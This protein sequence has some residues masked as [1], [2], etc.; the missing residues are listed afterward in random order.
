MSEQAYP[1]ALTTVQRVKDL[2]GITVSNADPVLLRLVNSATDFIQN[3]CNEFFAQKTYSNELYSIW[4]ERQEYLMLNHGNVTALTSF[5][6]RAGTP[7]TPNWTNFVQDQYELVEPDGSG[8]ARSGMVRIYAGFAPL[9]YT[10]TNAIRATYTAGFLISWPD[11]GDPT[12]HNLPADL[13][14]LC[15]NLIVRYW[16]HRES[17]GKKSESVKDSNVTWNDFVDGFDADVLERYMRP[18]RFI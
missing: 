7:T 17:S 6:Y 18:V 15:E 12:K 14:N 10:G 8:I 11:F 9:L 2:L 13:S 5:Q 4:G 1:Y 16:K 3:Y